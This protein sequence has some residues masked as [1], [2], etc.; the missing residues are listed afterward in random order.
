MSQDI[1]GQQ[2]V[3]G[4]CDFDIGGLTVNESYR[5]SRQLIDR[6]IVGLNWLIGTLV[7]GLERDCIEGL[8]S[9]HCA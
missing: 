2:E 8:R 1:L 4:V 6:G 9:L 5:V 7:G 3:A